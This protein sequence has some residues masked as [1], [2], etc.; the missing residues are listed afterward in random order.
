MP[1]IQKVFITTDDTGN[2]YEFPRTR[3]QENI[4]LWEVQ[5]TMKSVE[6]SSGLTIERGTSGRFYVER[7]T[8]EK[9][10]MLGK[11]VEPLPTSEDSLK[12][13]QNE[14]RE[15]LEK[16]LSLVGVYPES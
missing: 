8:I 1:K 4:H 12:R 11:R 3:K 13:H 16:L 9:L 14:L 7:S 15:T 5:V 6:D 2:V 10:G